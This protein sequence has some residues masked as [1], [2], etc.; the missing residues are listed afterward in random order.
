MTVGDIR[1]TW[2][3]KSM[4]AHTLCDPALYETANQNYVIYIQNLSR[5]QAHSKKRRKKKQA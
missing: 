4:T 2:I 3:G 5:S 1:Q